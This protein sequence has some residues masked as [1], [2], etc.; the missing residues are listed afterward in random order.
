MEEVTN[1]EW[2]VQYNGCYQVNSI[3]LGASSMV[4][5]ARWN[6]S[7]EN[8]YLVAQSPIFNIYRYMAYHHIMSDISSK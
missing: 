1:I 7:N 3:S 4:G 8:I 6:I 2:G 5:N